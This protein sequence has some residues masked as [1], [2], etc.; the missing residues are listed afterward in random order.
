MS[1]IGRNDP[2]PCGSGKKYKN[3]C[4][5]SGSNVIPFHVEIP[6]DDD[7]ERFRH[8]VD[9]W[10]ESQGPPPTFNQFMGKPNAA[11]DV[12]EQLS[13]EIQKHDFDSLEDFQ[14]FLDARN[15][16]HNNAPLDYFLGLSPRQMMRLTYSSFEQNTDLVTFSDDIPDKLLSDVPFIREVHWFLK[17]LEATQKGVKATKKGNL[18]RALVQDYYKEFVPDLAFK[19]FIPRSEDEC[20]GIR[21]VKYYLKDRGLIKFRSGHYSL[22][23]KG[24]NCISK[25]TLFDLYKD[26]F[27]WWADEFN[28]LYGTVLPQKDS[29][30]Q[31]TLIFNLL[32]LKK[33]AK[34]FVSAEDLSAVYLTAF[35]HLDED[36]FTGEFLGFAILF[37]ESFCNA[38]GLLERNLTKNSFVDIMDDMY[39]ITQLFEKLFIWHIG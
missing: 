11:T 2:C 34:E 33:E 21:I 4:L 12:I 10:D 20:Y 16:A 6:D 7:L 9:N 39:K 26:I 38:L 5:K 30:I 22:T 19:F 31:S 36:S 13:Q 14:N 32:I 24:V 18:P 8:L 37:L 3:C 27:S 35:P 17:K 29:Y 25:I 23:Q 1:K 28:W 15:D